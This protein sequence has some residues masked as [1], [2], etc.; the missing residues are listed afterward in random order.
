MRGSVLVILFYLQ[1]AYG[2]DESVAAAENLVRMRHNPDQ[3][4]EKEEAGP[5]EQA[6]EKKPRVFTMAR[7][8]KEKLTSELQSSEKDEELNKQNVLMSRT[9]KNKVMVTVNPEGTVEESKNTGL[10]RSP[11]NR[12]QVPVGAHVIESSV[13]EKAEVVPPESVVESQEEGLGTTVKAVTTA[14]TT[15]Y[16]VTPPESADTH[17]NNGSAYC[18]AYCG[19]NWNNELGSRGW[20]GAC[21]RKGTRLSD[22]A[23][24]SCTTTTVGDLRCTCERDDSLGWAAGSQN[25]FYTGHVCS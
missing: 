1:S 4:E 3:Q 9:G 5:G 6:T 10:V 8:G 23:E 20:A 19:Y 16:I 18:S 14:M 11:K 22:G 21:C 12:V 15:V 17:A 2:A 7:K 25:R 24:V 13:V